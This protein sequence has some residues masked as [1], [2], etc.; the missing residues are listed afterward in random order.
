M[1]IK[2]IVAGLATMFLASLAFADLE[3]WKDYEVSDSV[4]LVTAV[5]VDANMDD[6]YLEGIKQTW[7]ASNDVAKE[8]GQIVDYRIFRSDLPQSGDFNL[9]LVIEFA[10]TADLAPNKE[11][12]DAFIE[13][14]GQANADASTDYAQKNYPGMRKIT[15][16]Y[17]MREITLK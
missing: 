16:D 15:G 1:R 14:W 7:A 8:L 2:L 3:P 4:F 6:A 5:Q 12:Y 11:R 10:N 13:S 17:M 9:L